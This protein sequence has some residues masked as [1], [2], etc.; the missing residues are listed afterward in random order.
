MKVYI[1]GYGSLMSPASVG[2]T[3]K[4]D[5]TLNDLIPVMVQGYRRLWSLKER[6]F[7]IALQEEISVAFLD[8]EPVPGAMVNGTLVQINQEEFDYLKI[9][10]KNYKCIDITQTTSFEEED[11]QIYT[12]IANEE[13]KIHDADSQG[14]Y[15]MRR[16]VNLVESAC[17]QFGNDFVETYKTTT[18]PTSLPIL[19]GDYHFVDPEQR[20]SV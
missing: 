6:V 4:R 15:I 16:Y 10:E 2:R 20:K 7:S 1:F 18:L 11:C 12:F 8:I 13:H 5:V 17:K 14:I 19:D 3:L 9:R